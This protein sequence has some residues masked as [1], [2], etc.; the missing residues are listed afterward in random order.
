MSSALL[1]TAGVPRHLPPATSISMDDLSKSVTYPAPVWPPEKFGVHPWGHQEGGSD[2]LGGRCA[3][4]P[5]ELYAGLDD[6]EKQRA[7]RVEEHLWRLSQS[8]PTE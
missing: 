3:A 8:E 1:P 6:H 7:A 5:S 2:S 4:P